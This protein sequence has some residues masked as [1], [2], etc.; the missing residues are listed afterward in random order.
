MT[1]WQVNK[2]AQMQLTV[3]AGLIHRRRECK[4]RNNDLF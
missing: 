1:I 2:A 3:Q 4:E